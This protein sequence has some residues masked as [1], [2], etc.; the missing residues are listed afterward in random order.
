MCTR[1]RAHT[2]RFP[3]QPIIIEGYPKNVTALTDS[4][5]TFRCPVFSDV[6]VYVQW[7][8]YHA[9]N[10]TDLRNETEWQVGRARPGHFGALCMGGGVLQWFSSVIG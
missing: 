8:K 10:N 3:S 7:A 9:H 2:D 5:V 4:N 1:A 6:A